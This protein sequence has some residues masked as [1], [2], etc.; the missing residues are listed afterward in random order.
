MIAFTWSGDT[1][2]C[3]EIVVKETWSDSA[4]S[5]I[6]LIWLGVRAGALDITV[7]VFPFYFVEL[8]FPPIDSIPQNIS[9]IIAF[10]GPSGIG[11]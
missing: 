7:A 9:G 8:S 1:P 11:W 5:I 4:I 10:H 6:S 3:A 2:C